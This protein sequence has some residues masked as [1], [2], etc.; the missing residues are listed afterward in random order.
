MALAGWYNT[1]A[2]RGESGRRI[3]DFGV[4]AMKVI[5]EDSVD[6]EPLHIRFRLK[7]T[8]TSERCESLAGF[9]LEWMR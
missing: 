6:W 7:G 1:A 3:A 9:V 2:G 5:H 4:R 8:P